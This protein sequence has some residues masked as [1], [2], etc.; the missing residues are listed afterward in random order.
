VTANKTPRRMLTE[1]L[2]ELDPAKVFGIV[3]NGDDR[4]LSRYYGYYNA[5]PAGRGR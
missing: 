4:T 2:K 1:A 3:F 5:D